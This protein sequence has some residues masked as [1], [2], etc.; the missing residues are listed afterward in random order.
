MN[1]QQI[2]EA[3]PIEAT[4]PT[5]TDP[6]PE[7]VEATKPAEKEPDLDRAFMALKRKRE[8]AARDR[9]ALENDR[10]ALA[11]EREAHA[12][13][14]ALLKRVRERDDTALTELLGEDFFDRETQRRLD[15]EGA[16]KEKALRDQLSARDQQLQELRARLDRLDQERQTVQIQAQQRSLL[17]KARAHAAPELRILEDHELIGMA[18]RIATK[19]EEETGQPPLITDLLAAIAEETRPRYKRL[20]ELI[21]APTAAKPAAAKVAP[22]APA[23]VTAEDAS[24]PAGTRGRTSDEEQFEEWAR[25]FR[26]ARQGAA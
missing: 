5:P 7:P 1:D 16:A 15:P 19:I 9:Q 21:G 4:D 24:T 17:D 2:T 3:A 14:I 10:R 8:A 12:K 23:S 22:K 26:A 11:A 18:D 20:Q 13:E 6:T 25:Q